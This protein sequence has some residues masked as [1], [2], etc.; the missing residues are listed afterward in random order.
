MERYFIGAGALLEAGE[1]STITRATLHAQLTC[2]AMPA[3]ALVDFESG[4]PGAVR[5]LL[6]FAGGFT[7]ERFEAAVTDRL[8][9]AGVCGIEDIA[10]LLAA[11][12]DTAEVH[13]FARWVPPAGMTAALA[14]RGVALRAHPLEEIARAALIA[15]HRFSAWSGPPRAA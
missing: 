3:A 5:R 6:A 14:E 13:L 12:A 9:R 15:E 11:G 1:R 7:A 8:H 2:E 4:A 10:A